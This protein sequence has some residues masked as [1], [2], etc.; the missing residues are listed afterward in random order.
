MTS[1]KILRETKSGIRYPLLKI[2]APLVPNGLSNEGGLPVR[3]KARLV[4]LGYRVL[5]TYLAL[6]CF[7]SLTN[8]KVLLQL[9]PLSC[10]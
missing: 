8:L 9:L 7:H 5:F 3:N 4:A 10:P 2:V 1:L 6:G